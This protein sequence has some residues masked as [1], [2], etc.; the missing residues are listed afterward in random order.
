MSL[1]HSIKQTILTLLKYC[2]KNNWAGFDPFDGLNSQIFETLPLLKNRISRLIFIQAMKR[3][4]VNLR[5]IFLVPKAQNPKGLA[6][7]C[8]TLIKLHNLNLMENDRQIINLLN[9]LIEMRSRDTDYH[10]WGYNFD[11]QN[12]QFFLPKYSPNIICTTFAG[13]ALLDAYK[14]FND[15]KYLDMAVSSGNF[16]L[17]GLNIYRNKDELCFSYTPFDTGQVHNANLLGAAF[18]SRLHSITH[19]EKYLESAKSAVRF[20]A[21][22]QRED[23]SWVYGE[24][25]K[26]QWVDNFHTGYNL[27]ALKRF[28]EYTKTTEYNKNIQE[29]F[30]FYKENLF[31]KDGLPKYFNNQLYPIDIHAIAYSIITLAEFKSLD[32]NNLDLANHIFDWTMANMW[33]KRGYFYYQKKKFFKIRI[34]YMRWSQAWMLY[35]LSILQENYEV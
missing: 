23:G 27:I 12:R 30:R 10:C 6:L 24:D 20:S 29:G 1:N 22:R 8:S 35:A 26:Q 32:D 7:F 28:S 11:W 13:N 18:L 17:N 16:I 33:D 31:T 9:R 19:E 5:H 4:P 14:K 21:R 34:P 2:E 25:K 3:S 15:D